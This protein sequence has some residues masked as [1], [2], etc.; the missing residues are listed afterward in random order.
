MAPSLTKRKEIAEDTIARTP[1]IVAA[2]PGAFSESTFI[3]DQLSPLSPGS[4]PNFPP[5]TIKVGKLDA[6]TTAR[7]ILKKS[8]EMR[9]KVTVLNLASDEIR[10][11]GWRQTLAKTQVCAH[12]RG[13]SDL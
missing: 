8:P 12:C 10:A 4:C 5:L 2:T 3:R 11:G 1:S 7:N 9:G 6:F 13:F